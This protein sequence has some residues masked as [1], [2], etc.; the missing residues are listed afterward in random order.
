MSTNSDTPETDAV[1]INAYTAGIPPRGFYVPA[2]HARK[3]ERERDQLR[4][5]VAAL[6]DALQWCLEKEPS[7]CRC[8][9]FASPPHV[10]VA[11]RAL[12]ARKEGKLS[13]K[14]H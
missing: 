9:G 11:H 10:C 13:H 12:N 5:E 4:A 8:V 1:E 6:R 14:H 7:P 3:L 2:G